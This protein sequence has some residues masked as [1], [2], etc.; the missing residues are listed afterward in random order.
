MYFDFCRT[1]TE[2]KQCNEVESITTEG[3]QGSDFQET[4][5]SLTKKK[6]SDEKV[7]L[8]SANGE[9]DHLTLTYTSD[10]D[11]EYNEEV[12]FGVTYE[13]FCDSSIG[14]QPEFAIDANR[15][16]D[17][18]P[19]FTTRH[20]SGCKVG[21]LNGLWRF[22]ETNNIVFGIICILLGLYLTVLGRKLIRPTI[23]LI[24]WMVIILVILFLFYVLFLP[25]DVDAW[26]GWVLLS[27]SVVL[28][29]IGGFFASKLIRVGVFFLGLLSGAGV[30]LL[31]NNIVFYKIN[32]IATLWV[33]MGVLGLAFGVCSFFWYNYVVI[34]CTSILGSYLFVRGIGMMAGGYPN[35]F[36]IYQRISAGDIGSVPWTFYMYMIGIVICT[37]MSIF[38][39]IKIKR[40]EGDSE[41]DDKAKDIYR[42]V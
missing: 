40:R 31:L 28:G 12:K 26:V 30:G 41:S 14:E 29:W 23:G 13:V 32:H 2:T 15:T 3:V 25:N 34:L 39:Q 8:S 6:G 9:S 24:F 17:C 4:C 7:T 19:Y 18:R 11:C 37:I 22:I 20:R 42:R 1:L 10:Q 5:R 36:T 33:L 27:I 16:Q 35:E 21:D 38:L